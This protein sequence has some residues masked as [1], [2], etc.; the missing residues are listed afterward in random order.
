M[1][2][3][4]GGELLV[5][6]LEA[7]GADTFFSISGGQLL[8]IYDAIRA[9]P[10]LKLITPRTEWAAASMADGYT[11]VKGKPAVV[12]STV[13]AGAVCAVPGIA[14]AWADKI[15]IISI[16]PQVQ[17]WKMDPLHENLQGCY[18]EQLFKPIT[19]WNGVVRQWQRIPEMVQKAF[20]EALSGRRGPAHL[21]IPAD[22]LFESRSVREK[23]LEKM[24]AGPDKTRFTGEIRGDPQRIRKAVEMLKSS[25]RPLILAGGG[26]NA[27]GAREALMAFIDHVRIPATTS[28]GGMGAV[29][30][31]HPCYIGGPSYIGG[32]P[33]HKAIKE[34]DVVLGIGATFG[35]LE[36]F[37]KPPLWGE[38][39]KFIIVDIDPSMIGLNVLPEIAIIG[40]A[41][42]VLRDMLEEAKDIS[43]Q[44]WQETKWME[45]LREEKRKWDAK[46][47]A[48]ADPTAKPIHPGY[49]IKTLREMAPSDAIAIVDGGN[50]ALWSAT[51][52][53][54]DSP[55]SNFFPCGLATLGVGI[56]LAIGARIAEP[57]RPVCLIAGDGAFMYN[58]QELETAHRYGIP[59]GIV[60]MN[61]GRYNMIRMAQTY[62]F[63]GR[64]IGTDIEGVD[65]AGAVRGFGGMA[66]TVENPQELKNALEDI[67]H[68]D[69]V[70]LVDVR[71]DPYTAP[72]QL[73]SFA[74]VEFD[75]L[76]ID[77]IKSFLGNIVNPDIMKGKNPLNR[78]GYIIKTWK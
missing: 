32:E 77:Y 30:I 7:Q 57:N 4:T 52:G 53:L 28:M 66:V 35:G 20:R 18:Q 73:T 39:I 56:P 47:S 34:A 48:E 72:M 40:D 16:S 13:G 62:M 64:Y 11:R 41:K 63:G 75:G 61:D 9:R 2:K 25:Q 59:L 37:G 36:G 44:P 51:Y 6:C 38:D 26:V 67:A 29:S 19:K 71:I 3:M 8:T 24:L 78:I 54:L 17:S 33:F 55:A 76:E 58:L 1:S 43:A 21:D 15:P 31:T 49:V 10:S 23:E 5:R 27:S 14:T 65:Y 42:S 74:R 60:L 22:I 46:V 68:P 50:T 70:K 12:M 45:T 69:G